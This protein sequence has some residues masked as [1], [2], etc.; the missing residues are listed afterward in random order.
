MTIVSSVNVSAPGQHA[1]MSWLIGPP[2]LL[3]DGVA[4]GRPMALAETRAAL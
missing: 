3:R 4:L 1:A 2:L